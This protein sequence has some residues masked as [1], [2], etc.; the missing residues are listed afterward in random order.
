M[1]A[2]FRGAKFSIDSIGSLVVDDA[3][4]G[5]IVDEALDDI[6]HEFGF[7]TDVSGVEEYCDALQSLGPAIFNRKEWKG[8]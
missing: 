7:D 8:E 4:S 5:R 2:E 6:A 3:Q 1:V